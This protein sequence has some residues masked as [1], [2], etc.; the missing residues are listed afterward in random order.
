MKYRVPV[1]I[2]RDVRFGDFVCPGKP[3]SIECK[4]EFY[5]LS[6]HDKTENEKI[7]S[8]NKRVKLEIRVLIV[9]SA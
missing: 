8:L 3:I 4:I 2:K 1:A 7:G 5:P 6:L 9:G